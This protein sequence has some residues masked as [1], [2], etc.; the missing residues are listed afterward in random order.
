MFNIINTSGGPLTITGFAQGPGANNSALNNVA[1]IV[2]YTPGDYL[3]QPTASWVQLASGTVSLSPNKCTGY[4][5]VSVTIPTGATYGFFVGLVSNIVQYTS[6][7][8]TPGVTPWFT[9]NDMVIT[10]GRGG[11][12]PNPAFS[13]RNW[14]GK[15]Y[16]GTVGCSEIRKEV[17]FAVSTDTAKAVIASATQT[18]PGQF[19]FASSGSNGH[20]Y[21]W[22]FGNGLTASGPTA[23]TTYTSGGAFT[24]TLVVTDTVCGTVDST[25]TVVNS[26]IGLNEFGLDQAVQVY[27]NPSNGL[28]Q[29]VFEGSAL[30]GNLELVNPLGQVVLAQTFAKDS[31]V[32]HHPL[33]LSDLAKGIYHVRILS[34]EGSTVL[35]VVLQ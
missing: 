13:P 19:S 28:V 12:F 21:Q 23:S 27:P 29:L 26:T 30:D 20:L 6:G 24:V 34:S 9:N 10:Q 11:T 3:T 14:N 18:A 15:V 22:T 2:H 1:M 16:Y 31:G 4:L 7:T 5:P 8:G 32:Y 35:R 33:N 25:F 17:S